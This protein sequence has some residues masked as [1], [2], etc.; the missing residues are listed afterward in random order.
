[1]SANNFSVKTALLKR[2]ISKQLT[3]AIIDK[4]ET[5]LD[6]DIHELDL[7]SDDVDWMKLH[8]NVT[9]SIA[10]DDLAKLLER[11]TW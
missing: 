3:K 7:D 5:D 2:A 10:G 11:G 4:L 8:I 6:I 9:V 1:M